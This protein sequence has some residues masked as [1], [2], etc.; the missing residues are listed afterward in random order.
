MPQVTWA[1]GGLPAAARPAVGALIN[2]AEERVIDVRNAR[3]TA[4]EETE[5]NGGLAAECIDVAL[6]YGCA[7]A[8]EP[9]PEPTRP[10]RAILPSSRQALTFSGRAKGLPSLS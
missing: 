3:K 7:P 4:F 8:G 2:A 6:Q 9:D 10:S 1:A 5:L